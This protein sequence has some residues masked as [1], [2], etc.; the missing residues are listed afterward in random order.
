MVLS[1]V[2][3]AIWK[4]I[5][6]DNKDQWLPAFRISHSGELVC[7]LI[8]AASLQAEVI[9]RLI[10][11]AFSL[12]RLV[13]AVV[14]LLVGPFLFQLIASACLSGQFAFQLESENVWMAYGVCCGM[15]VGSVIIFI[16]LRLLDTRIAKNVGPTMENWGQV[17]LS[18]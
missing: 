4:A 17:D 10:L 14:L 15:A 11:G 8:L 13:G 3:I 6:P 16:P 7:G 1:D 9:A 2:G 5:M 18:N 12:Y